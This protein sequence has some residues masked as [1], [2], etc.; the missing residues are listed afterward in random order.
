MEDDRMRS[1]AHLR[2]LMA[3]GNHS[4]KNGWSRPSLKRIGVLAGKKD[5]PLSKP[6]VSEIISDLEAWGYLTRNAQTRD[7]GGQTSNLYRVIFDCGDPEPCPLDPVPDGADPH[8]VS[9]N[10]P[11]GPI[12]TNPPFA[13]MGPN[14][15][16]TTQL[17]NEK[18]R[19]LWTSRQ[20]S[21][22]LTRLCRLTPTR[23]TRF[24]NLVLIP[25]GCWTCSTNIARP[26]QRFVC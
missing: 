8:S 18:K 2:V 3:I 4:D 11:F 16:R 5:K 22:P 9:Q 12:G 21:L 6:Y 20:N 26:C 15:I 24:A 14:P 25:I 10:P 13:P 23:P 17:N 19:L 1:M 7:D